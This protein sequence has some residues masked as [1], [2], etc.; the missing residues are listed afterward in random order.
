MYVAIEERIG[1]QLGST[2]GGDEMAALR[3]ENER[4]QELVSQRTKDLDEQTG[5]SLDALDGYNTIDEMTEKAEAVAEALSATPD[6]AA[7]HESINWRR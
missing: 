3:A 5:T 2:G 7:L 4:L 6:Q 1:Q